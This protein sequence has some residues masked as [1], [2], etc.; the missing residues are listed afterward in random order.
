MP[1]VDGLGDDQASFLVEVD[2]VKILHC[3]DTLWHGYWY[4][5]AVDYG[6]INLAFLPINGALIEVPGVVRTG[7]PVVMTPTQ[8]AAAADVICAGAV[9]P[10]HY[11]MFNH[12]PGFAEWPDALEVFLEE[13]RRRNLPTRVLAPGEEM[14]LDRAPPTAD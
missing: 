13:T 12:P 3:G 10:M 4:K 9:C 7:V 14:L 1:A 6:P 2:G 8:A 5:F 11:G